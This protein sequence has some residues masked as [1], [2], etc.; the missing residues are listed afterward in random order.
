VTDSPDIRSHLRRL[1][2]QTVRTLSGRPNTVLRLEGDRVIV[3]TKKSPAGV[4]VE[5]R[6]LQDAADRLFM[7]G[8]AKI[9][10]ASVGYRSAFVGAVLA[11]LPNA[12]AGPGQR[13]RLI[14]EDGS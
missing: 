12:V 14:R 8:E 1:E 10:V 9:N 4:P 5:M 13:V 11:A 6:E 2:G 7:Y 3:G